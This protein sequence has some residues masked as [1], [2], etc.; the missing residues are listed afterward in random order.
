MFLAIQVCPSL[1]WG[2]FTGWNCLKF[3][4]NGVS[5]LS[6]QPLYTLFIGAKIHII[7]TVGEYANLLW[8]FNQIVPIY[9]NLHVLSLLVPFI[10]NV[11][12][13]S[14]GNINLSQISIMRFLN[15]GVLSSIFLLFFLIFNF[16]RILSNMVLMYLEANTPPLERTGYTW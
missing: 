3:Y 9:D 1:F 15:V 11:H 14:Y 2:K 6:F 8:K 13:V 4:F 5:A 10:F 7:V 12:Y 16:V